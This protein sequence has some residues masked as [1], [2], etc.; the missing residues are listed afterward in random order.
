MANYVCMY[1][2]TFSIHQWPGESS[3]G[4]GLLIDRDRLISRKS[5]L[6]IAKFNDDSGR[7]ASALAGLSVQ[8]FPKTLLF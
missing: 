7:S 1:V 4:A 3:G 8:Q 5:F 6:V 2:C